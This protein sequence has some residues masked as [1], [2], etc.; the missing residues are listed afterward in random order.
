MIEFRTL[1]TIELLRPDGTL[2]LS[3]ASRSKAL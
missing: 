2:V 3:V 1:G